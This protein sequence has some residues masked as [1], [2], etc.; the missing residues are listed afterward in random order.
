[1]TVQSVRVGSTSLKKWQLHG[2]IDQAL[3][4]TAQACA[5]KVY[6]LSVEVHGTN[7]ELELWVNAEE[8]E[9]TADF[10]P[11][12]TVML[13]RN[14]MRKC[15]IRPPKNAG[16]LKKLLLASDV[17]QQLPLVQGAAVLTGAG[18]TDIPEEELEC[19]LMALVGNHDHDDETEEEE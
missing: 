6:P 19:L 9:D 16:D 5:M 3:K 4:T 18:C 2:P 10:N 1:M 7:V 15:G 12:A 17:L 8:A 14:E 13:Q 11:P